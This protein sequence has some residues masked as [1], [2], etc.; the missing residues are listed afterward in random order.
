M[1]TKE[2]T[3]RVLGALMLLA[4]AAFQI[5]HFADF[6]NGRTLMVFGLMISLTTYVGYAK[7]LKAENEELRRQLPLTN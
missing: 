2:K 7:R 1:N 6:G 4:G 5:F 3:Q